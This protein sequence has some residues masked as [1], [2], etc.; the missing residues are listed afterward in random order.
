MEY[1]KIIDLLDNTPNEPS[2]FRTKNWVEINDDSR[3][4]DNTNS[5]IKFKTSMLRSSL[6]DYS[7]A[8]ILVSGTITVAALTAGGENNNI[9]VVFKNCAQFANYINE[10]NNTQI[11][12]AK[13]SDAVMPLYNLMDYR[14]N[15]SKTSGCLSHYYR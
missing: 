15:Y 8:Y 10:K 14:D 5:Q 11:D 13:D 1:K 2:K 12:N 3:G 6:C 9:Q 7:D 4:T